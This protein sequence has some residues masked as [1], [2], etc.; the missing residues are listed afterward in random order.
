[1]SHRHKGADWFSVTAIAGSDRLT[2]PPPPPGGEAEADR[3]HSQ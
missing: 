3:T 1:M 2:V